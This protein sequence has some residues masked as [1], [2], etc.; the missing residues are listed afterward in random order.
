M[1]HE[2]TLTGIVL[3][4]SAAVFSQE[5][6]DSLSFKE[7]E[8]LYEQQISA[9]PSDLGAKLGLGELYLD[10]EKSSKALDVFETIIQEDSLLLDST[11]YNAYAGAGEALILMQD[12]DSLAIQYLKKGLK[13]RADSLVDEK[14]NLYLLIAEGYNSLSKDMI[15]EPAA[16]RYQYLTLANALDTTN[17]ETR[18]KRAVYLDEQGFF[19]EAADE[20]E[21][22]W[23]WE[24][25]NAASE[26]REPQ[27]YIFREARVLRNKVDKLSDD[28][29]KAYYQRKMT[30]TKKNSVVIDPQE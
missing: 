15:G 22:A 9:D 12:Q 3:L 6:P 14:I 4:S 8:Q 30:V 28:E 5:V 2:V 11:T 21:E 20:F 25:I 24:Q 19:V 10:A 1:K 7:K 23:K 27:K 18:Y 17:A 16:L 29:L 26:G 13:G